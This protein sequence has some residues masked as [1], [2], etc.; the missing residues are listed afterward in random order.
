M[1]N[2]E[3]IAFA[4]RFL[5]SNLDNEVYSTITNIDSDNCV[6]EIAEKTIEKAM[7]QTERRL[8]NLAEAIEDSMFQLIDLANLLQEE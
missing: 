8:N 1:T 4:L 5:A 2:Q 3:L 7:D 6:V